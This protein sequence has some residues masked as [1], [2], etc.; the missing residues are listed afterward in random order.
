MKLLIAYA[1][2]H[3][4]LPYRWGGD[5]PIEGYDCSGLVQEILAS[6]GAD[7]AGDQ[8][9][10][11]LYRHFVKYGHKIDAPAP[12]ALAFYGTQARIK[13][14]GFCLDS[15]RMLEAGGG[16]SKTLTVGDA[17]AQNA[18]VRIRTVKFR[19]DLVEVILPRYHL[20]KD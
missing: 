17:A 10:D 1:M 4:G 5:D 20:P 16:G 2:A 15:H 9:A 3:V 12:G 7:P 11:G 18:Y 13:H 19:K 14:V 6:V 8:T